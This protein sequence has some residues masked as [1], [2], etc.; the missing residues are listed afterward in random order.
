MIASAYGINGLIA[1]WDV[2]CSFSL[3]QGAYVNTPLCDDDT[4][5]DVV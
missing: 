5:S 4:K 2:E 3:M 1:L